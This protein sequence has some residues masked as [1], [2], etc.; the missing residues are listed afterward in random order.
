MAA[1]AARPTPL[2]P[3]EPVSVR[4]D[5]R[6]SIS[7][8]PAAARKTGDQSERRAGVGQPGRGL[9]GSL[10]RCRAPCP[11]PWRGQPGT[12]GRRWNQKGRC[13]VVAFAGNP[14]SFGLGERCRGQT[15]QRMLAV[16]VRGR[17]RID[18]N[19]GLIRLRVRPPARRGRRARGAPHTSS[20]LA[21]EGPSGECWGAGA[22]PRIDNNTRA[23][24][25]FPVPNDALRRSVH[26]REFG[27]THE[28][29]A[30]PRHW[31]VLDGEGGG[32]NP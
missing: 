6:G 4:S 23:V 11:H 3:D 25:S 20:S 24:R 1:S 30:I 8:G 21:R 31:L 12:A 15:L 13:P 32:R 22:H 16:R 14:L 18:H 9:R 19:R 7:G 28:P 10:Y 26:S 17:V 2:I 27:G 5:W 29:G